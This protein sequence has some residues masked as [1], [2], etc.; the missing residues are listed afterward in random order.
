MYIV[1]KTI[2]KKRYAYLQ[3]SY[4]V[5]KKVKTESKYLGPAGSGGVSFET[6]DERRRRREMNEEYAREM[7]RL[8]R[9]GQELD[10]WQRKAFGQTGAERQERERQEHLDQLKEEFGLRLPS[11]T[12]VK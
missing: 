9:E 5:G 7:G 6:K 2:K 8:E 11:E 1:Y 10:D 4:R 12:E 3:R